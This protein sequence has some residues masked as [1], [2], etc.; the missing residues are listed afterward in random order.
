MIR[1]PIAASRKAVAVSRYV[2][3]ALFNALAV[4]LAWLVRSIISK[5][6]VVQRPAGDEGDPTVLI[7]DF[8]DSAPG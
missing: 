3:L 7:A 1:L 2:S 5:K 8:R 4:K 6:A